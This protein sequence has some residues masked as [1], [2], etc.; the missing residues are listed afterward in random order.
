[1]WK[2]EIETKESES[3]CTN[4]RFQKKISCSI[5]SPKFL[6]A[7]CLIK[8]MPRSAEECPMLLHHRFL[9]QQ[10]TNHNTWIQNDCPLRY[11]PVF[12]KCMLELRLLPNHLLPFKNQTAWRTE[13]SLWRQSHLY[14][15]SMWM[16]W[17]Q[18]LP[19][20]TCSVSLISR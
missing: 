1:M 7:H 18:Q 8:V 4:S 17:L 10:L 2:P 5:C 16:L 19:G 6:L 15:S 13:T 3:E 20:E 11:V 9:W 12:S 14:S